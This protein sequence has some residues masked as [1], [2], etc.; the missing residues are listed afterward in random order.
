MKHNLIF[1]STA[2]KYWYPD[3]NRTPNDLDY[4]SKEGKSIKG[5]EYHWTEGFQYILDNNKDDIYVDADFLYTIKMSHA[6]YDVRWEKTMYD[7]RFLKSKGCKVDEMLFKILLKDWELIHGEKK[8][9]LKGSPDQFFTEKV[10]RKYNH[11]ELHHKVMFYDRPMHERIRPDINDVKTSKKLWDT[12]SQ[13][14][15]LKCALEESYVFAIERYFNLPPKIALSKAIK[16]L[17]VSSTKGYFNYFII[18]NF[19]EMLYSNHSKYLKVFEEIK[20][21]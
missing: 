5:V 9:K 2:L 17:I 14:D 16:H 21:E 12:L 3:F 20:N 4:I 13:E 7:I 8:I 6:C 18:D 1:G 10:S 11:D 19:F 15:K